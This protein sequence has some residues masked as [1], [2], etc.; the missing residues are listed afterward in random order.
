MS[1]RRTKAPTLQLTDI[2]AT[3][4]LTAVVSYHEE[5]LAR[6]HAEAPFSLAWEKLREQSTPLLRA[7]EKLQ[8]YQ[9]ITGDDEEVA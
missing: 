7:I 1:T 4:V 2:E 6:M 9:G 8:D 5:L 3:Q